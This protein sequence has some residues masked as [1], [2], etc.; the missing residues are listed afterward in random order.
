MD[1]TVFSS[2][3]WATPQKAEAAL[4]HA[5][6]TAH[7]TLPGTGCLVDLRV[8]GQPLEA[9]VRALASQQR[10]HRQAGSPSRPLRRPAAPGTGGN[11][12]L[13]SSSASQRMFILIFRFLKLTNAS[14]LQA[15]DGHFC[16]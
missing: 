10:G 15:N 11:A 13:C 7:R 3:V 12:P 16:S 5:G 14:L 4:S 2:G 8:T 6:D 9:H 1:Q